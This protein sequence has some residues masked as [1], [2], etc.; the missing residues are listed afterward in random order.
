MNYIIYKDGEEVNR[1]VADEEFCRQYYS[2]DG[3][4]FEEEPPRPEPE[5]EP[6]EAEALRAELTATQ[7]KLDAAI[8][9][10]AMLEDCLVE[11]AQ[12]VYA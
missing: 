8:Q 6:T 10:N 12:V 2:G 3:Y 7:K 5:P 1:I 9:S 11:M 4:S